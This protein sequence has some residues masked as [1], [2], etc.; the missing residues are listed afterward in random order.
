MKEKRKIEDCNIKRYPI[1]I[2]NAYMGVPGFFA[3]LLRNYD[4][5]NIINNLDVNVIYDILYLDANCLFHPQCFKVL[6]E[7]SD[8]KVTKTVLE[9]KMIKQICNYIIFLVNT[10]KPLKLYIAVD[11]VA[12]LA[13]ISQQRQRRFKSLIETDIRNKIKD[14]YNISYTKWSN[15][16]ITPGTVFMEKL[17]KELQRL[18]RSVGIPMEYS[19]Y[20][21]YGEGE[22]KI[23][24]HIKMNNYTKVC[25]YGLDADLIFLAIA[26]GRDIDL[27]REENQINNKD[28]DKLIIVKILELK[29]IINSIF[30]SLNTIYDYSNDFVVLCYL[31]GN[32]FLPHLPS[33]DI[34]HQGLDLLIKCYLICAGELKSMLVINNKINIIFMKRLIKKISDFEHNY[35]TKILPKYNN[36]KK[37]KPNDSYENEIYNFE[38]LI[39]LEVN[40]IINYSEPGYKERYYEHYFG[41]DILPIELC[42]EYIRGI[43]W[44]FEYYFN[45]CV[46]WK[47]QYPANHAP[48]ISDISNFLNRCPNNVNFLRT[49]TP[50]P[51]IYPLTQLL[52]VL[53]PDKNI[54]KLLPK[55]YRNLAELKDMFP[56]NI[57]L[58]YFNKDQ[59]WKVIANVP[60]IDIDRVVNVVKNINL[61][62]SDASRDICF[63]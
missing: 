62:R 9:S 25:V 8:K 57:S 45:K 47:W 24:Q 44:T 56:T 55:E 16:C 30:S 10:V 6:E 63:N 27:L 33:I 2:V 53:P 54:Q 26:S 41:S 37:A 39:G 28:G 51:F 46:C 7:H 34:K 1:Y 12:P 31:L 58:D 42:N 22:H 18:T 40:N 17:N 20:H 35:F 38:N 59:F 36:N 29:V 11:G 48:F 32:D 60:I 5:K 43:Y 49:V 13:K 52:V 61:K 3:W 50:K 15:S 23:L 4:N 19:S 21:E 14:K